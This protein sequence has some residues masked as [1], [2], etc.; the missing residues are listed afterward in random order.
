M[1][2]IRQRLLLWL[3]VGMLIS[4]GIAGLS[5]YWLAQDEANELFDYQIKQIALSLPGG[6]QLPAVTAEDEDP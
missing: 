2:S 5:M 1:N 3:I 6:S 4:T